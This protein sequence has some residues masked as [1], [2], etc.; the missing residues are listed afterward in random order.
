MRP[1]ALSQAK[2]AAQHADVKLLAI[3]RLLILAAVGALIA[4]GTHTAVA[5]ADPSPGAVQCKTPNSAVTVC[6]YPDGH[7]ESCTFGP[8]GRVVVQLVPGF[9]DGP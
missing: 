6:R 9:W 1:D 5:H 2:R 4:A 3:V 8:C 7:V